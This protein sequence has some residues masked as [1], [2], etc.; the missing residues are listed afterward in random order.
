MNLSTGGIVS[1]GGGSG[2]GSS[3]ISGIRSLN[4]L[5]GPDITLVGTSGI[6]ITPVAAT[7]INIG[8][9]GD[10]DQSGVI[11]V[12]GIDVEQVGG[13][14]VV[15]GSAI[16]GLI[17]PSGGVGGI[18]GQIGP[19]IEIKGVNGA[20]VTVPSENCILIDVVDVSGISTVNGDSGPAIDLVGVS[21]I[22]IYPFGDGTIFVG[23]SGDFLTSQSGVLGVNGINVEQI[24]G[25]FIVDGSSVSGLIEPSGGIGGI[26]GQI[27]PH[28]ELKGVNGIDVTVDSE[29]CILLD[30]VSISG[31]GG[32]GDVT[33][34]SSGV[35]SQFA[36][37]FTNTVSGLF[38]HNFGTRDVVVQVYDT[39]APPRKLIPDDIV[40]DTLDAVSVLFN[41]PQDGRVVIIGSGV[42]C[43]LSSDVGIEARRYSLLVS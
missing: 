26:N 43:S 33:V 20:D 8:F 5:T 27:G 9:T 1:F 16:S 30:G 37:S 39:S 42:A 3:S 35:S 29:N 22:Q 15:D 19:H 28:I 11:G 13:N 41:T 4:G 34:I 32:S 2:G 36:A 25:N 21:G 31:V 12:N 24:G 23:T 40:Y 10:V 7:Q 17:D 14:F 6:E 38:N 18:N